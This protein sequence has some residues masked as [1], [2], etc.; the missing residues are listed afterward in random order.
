MK[1]HRQYFSLLLILFIYLSVF[2][3]IF[4]AESYNIYSKRNLFSIQYFSKSNQI[5]SR[6]TKR[7][8]NNLNSITAFI[9]K[10]KKST[11]H[12]IKIKDKQFSSEISDFL[13]TSI[14]STFRINL[15]E[16]FLSLQYT[17]LR[18]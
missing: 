13:N 5:E 16:N 2:L 11:K 6:G 7:Y 3:K 4:S 17:P 18:I 14:Q 12:N 9:S 8:W 1:S 15:D 10:I